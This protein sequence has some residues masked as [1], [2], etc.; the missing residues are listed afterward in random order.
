MIKLLHPA[1][2]YSW[3]GTHSVSAGTMHTHI[4]KH[5]HA[6]TA[7]PGHTARQRGWPCLAG[8]TSSTADK[9]GCLSVCECV[10][11][12]MPMFVRTSLSLRIVHGASCAP[13]LHTPKPPE[14]NFRKKER[15]R[16]ITIAV[17][18][19]MYENSY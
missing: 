3:V 6:H 17:S 8:T 19:A 13:P 15:T 9:A 1:V 14:Q 4:Y 10:C 11:S 18:P 12:C 2:I 5:T 7:I 16:L